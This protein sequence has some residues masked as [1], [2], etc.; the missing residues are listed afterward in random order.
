MGCGAWCGI[1]G[2]G[3]DVRSEAF[4]QLEQYC[5]HLLIVF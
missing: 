4:C 2:G 1:N 3:Q 5:S